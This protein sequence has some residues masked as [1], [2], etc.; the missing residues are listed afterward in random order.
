MGENRGI[1]KAAGRARQ[2][3]APPTAATLQIGF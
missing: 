2:G 1:R 3:A